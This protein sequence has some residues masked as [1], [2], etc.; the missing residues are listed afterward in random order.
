MYTGTFKQQSEHR[1][2]IKVLKSMCRN[3]KMLLE[4][5]IVTSLTVSHA[6]AMDNSG[7]FEYHVLV[8]S[9]LFDQDETKR[10]VSILLMSLDALCCQN[11]LVK[12]RI[13][14]PTRCI[15]RLN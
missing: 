12:S 5:L 2:T 13:V 10:D 8:Y 9:G 3:F 14:Q 1:T 11:N 4:P 15:S 6:V 7:T